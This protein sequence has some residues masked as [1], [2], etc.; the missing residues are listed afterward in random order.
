MVLLSIKLQ[1]IPVGVSS[2]FD[3]IILSSQKGGVMQPILFSAKALPPKVNYEALFKF[4]PIRPLKEL[5]RLRGRPPFPRE[6]LLRAIVYMCLRRIDTLTELG[7]E[8]V[9]NPTVAEACGFNILKPLPNVE[10]FSSFLQDTENQILAGV[11]NALVRELISCGLITGKILSTDTCPIQAPVKENNLKTIVKDRFDKDKLPKGDPDARLG[12]IIHYPNPNDRKV[13]YFWGYKNF[14]IVDA[15]EELPVW[16]TTRPA[17]VHESTLFIPEFTHMQ[18]EFNFPIEIVT[19]DSAF[20]AEYILSFIKNGLKAKPVIARNP[21]NQ[22]PAPGLYTAGKMFCI[23]GLEMAN[24]G[25]SYMKRQGKR[26]RI[27]VCPIHHYK[28]IR[29][30]Y[31]LCPWNHPRFFKGKGCCHTVRVDDNIRD[32]INYESQDF[33]ELYKK[34]TTSERVFSR[35]LSICMQDITIRGLKAVKNRCTIAHIAV[36]LVALAAAKT[37]QR[38]KVRF[39]RSFVPN[40]VIS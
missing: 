10:R 25:T 16:E 6:A 18:K 14:S 8:M 11:R 35:L 1:N 28:R 32:S 30:R 12:V 13:H 29:K 23:A 24:R 36:L 5:E 3:G 9:N 33:K 2:F 40:F 4:L 37:G 27:F 38:D 39:V 19:A 21:R 31:I 7:F 34:R 15:K 22:S 20:D 26:Y 17:N